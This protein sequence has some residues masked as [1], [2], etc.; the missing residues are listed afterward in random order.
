MDGVCFTNFLRWM[1]SVKRMFMFLARQARL[2]WFRTRYSYN[3]NTCQLHLIKLLE[4][5]QIISLPCIYSAF[6]SHSHQGAMISHRLPE[7]RNKQPDVE[8]PS[9]ISA[10]YI[11]M[12]SNCSMICCLGNIGM[13]KAST[14]IMNCKHCL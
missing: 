6:N 7:I 2:S 10:V 11:Y 1:F 8:R 3:R 9:E 13:N 14:L 4:R 12:F 5:R